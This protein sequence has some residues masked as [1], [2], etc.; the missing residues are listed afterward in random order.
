MSAA[1]EKVTN[2]LQNIL[3][4]KIIDNNEEFKGWNV[5][6]CTASLI[7]SF[8][9][10]LSSIFEVS[11]ILEDLNVGRQSQQSLYLI[12]KLMKQ[13]EFFRENAK[14]DEL[15]F[16]EFQFYE[17]I[18][19]FYSE[20]LKRTKLK[21]KANWTPRFY[22][23]S[24]G[25]D[26]DIGNGI[27]PE[28]VFVFR[29]LTADNYR[30]GPREKLD[31]QHI[32]L[33]IEAIAKFH[34]V[35][36]ALKIQHK[37]K[38]TEFVKALKPF[39]FTEQ[40]KT[41]FDALYDI[42]LTRLHQHV[43]S[44]QQPE[45][46]KA[47]IE[48][49]YRNYI[50]K[51]SKLLQEFI[52]DDSQFNIII[53]G[54]YN[55]NNVM[56]K[57]EASEGFE[58]P[59]KVKMF[60]FQWIRYASP[61]LDISFCLYMNLDPELFETLWDN[62]LKFYHDTMF[63]T[64]TKILNC[65]DNDERIITLDY[66]SFQKHF[67]NYAFYGCL[68]SSW[69]I[70]IML[71]DFETCKNIEKELNKDLFS[72]E[73]KE[74][75][76]PAGGKDAVERLILQRNKNLK[77]K[78]IVQC[79][80]EACSTLDG[81]M[82]AIYS[83]TLELRDN[84]GYD[85]VLQ[86]IVKIMKGDKNFRDS[87]N[88]SIQC[89]NEVYIYNK[90]IPYFKKFLSECKSS[91]S[92]DWI[93]KVYFSDYQIFPE[94]SE[95]KE[96]ILALENLKPLGYRL[97]PRIDLDEKH[98]RL[99]ITH[100]ASY[101]AVSYAMRIKKDPMLDELAKG[102]IPFPYIQE[103]GTEMESY[104]VLFTIGL[105]RFFKVIKENPKLENEKG[106]LEAVKKFKD[107]YG[108]RPIYLLKKLMET[109][110]VFSILLHGD[111]N[112][113]NVLFLYD[114]AEGHENPKGLKMIDFQE[115]RYASPAIDL[116]F[117]MYMNMHFTL[118]PTLW[119]PVLELYH[120]T[121]I[122]SISEIL[123][124]DK[125]D[126]RL[127]P[128]SFNNFINHFKK[129]AFYGVIIGIHFIPWMACPEDEC[130]LMSEYWEADTNSPELR[131]L[132]QQKALI[133]M[134]KNMQ[135]KLNFVENE[136]PKLMMSQFVVEGKTIVRCCAK[137]KPQLDGFMSTIFTAD[138]LVRDSSG[139]ETLHKII[140]KIMKGEED[141][142]QKSKAFLQSSNE[143]FVY[144]TIIP[145]FSI[146]DASG[147]LSSD[148]W[149]SKVYFAECGN[150][151]SLSD[152]KETVVVLGDLNALGYRMSTSKLVLDA[153]HLELMA[154]KIA[155]YH[156]VSFAMKITKDPMFEKL[157]DGLTAFHIKSETQGDLDV[158]K[159]LCPIAFERA[160]QY[161]DK[162]EKYQKYQK[163]IIDLNNFKF[164]MNENFMSIMENFLRSDHQFAVILH[165]DYYRNNVMFKYE[166]ENGK[167][168]PTDLKMFDFQQV[169]YASVAIDLSFFMYMAVHASM[170]PLIWDKLLKV[171]HET[172]IE[173]MMRILMCNKDDERL[174]PYN[175]DDF[176]RN[177]EEFAFY[178]VVISVLLIPW[179][180]SPESESQLISE[181]FESDMHNPQFKE[182][183]L[184]CG[185]TDQK[186][187]I[188]MTKNM[189][190][191]LNF[192]ENELPKLMMSQFVVEG[193]T[194]VRCC[195]KPKPQLDGFMST[196]FT[197]DMLVKDASG[198]ETLHKI[199]VKIMKGEEDF[200]QK[201]KAF[202]QS[203]NEVFVYKTIIPYFSK[204]A[205]SGNL[206]SDDWISKVYFVECGNFE[207]LSDHKETIVV[208]E[209]LNA[210]GY[211]MSTS[212]LVLDAIHLELMARKIA[213]Y[214]AVS[215]AMKITKDLMFEKLIDG[216][217]PFHM[218]SETQGDL[219]VYKYLCPIAFERAFQYIDKSENYQ[220][221]QKFMKDLKNF[222][223]RMNENFM[224]IM[225]NFLRSDHQFAVI[226]HGDY[227]R[228]NVMFKYE[229][230]NG[231]EIPT[232]LKMFDFQEVRYA[233]VAIDLSIFMYMAVHASMKPLIWDELL[234]VYHETIIETLARILM[235]NKDDERFQP[236]NFDDFI[237]NF[238]E[239]AFYA[240][241]I[242]VLSIPWMASPESESQLIS[243][244]FE[245]DMHNP[246]FKELLLTC[247]GTDV[248]ERIID[249]IK[250]ANFELLAINSH[251]EYQLIRI[252]LYKFKSIIPNHS[253]IGETP[254]RKEQ[255]QSEIKMKK[256]FLIFIISVACSKAETFNIFKQ[257]KL[258]T[259]VTSRVERRN[260]TV[261]LDHFDRQNNAEW[262]LPYYIIDEFYQPNGPI[263]LR[264]AGAFDII[265]RLNEGLM[266]DLA[267]EFNA[268]IVGISL[269]FYGETRPTENLELENLRFLNSE[270][271]IG[272]IAH[273]VTWIKES[274]PS[275]ADSK[276]IAYGQLDGGSNAV[277]ARSK[278]PHLID[279][280][281]ASS[282][283]LHAVFDF[284]QMH[285]AI[286]NTLV[287]VGG[288]RC[289]QQ[290]ERAYEQ[291][292][293]LLQNQ[294]YE[295]IENSLNLCHNITNTTL[296]LGA[297]MN[298]LAVT[299]ASRFTEG[300]PT[301]TEEFCELMTSDLNDDDAFTRYAR[302]TR[303]VFSDN[304]IF[305][306]Y[307]ELRGLF[308]ANEWTM[309]GAQ[310]GFRQTLYQMCAEFG[311][312]S[313]SS[314]QYQPFGNRFPAEIFTD[315]CTEVFG[316]TFDEDFIRRQIELTNIMLG[317]AQPNVSNAY[318]TNGEMDPE[319]FLGVLRDINPT[320]RATVIP[321][322]GAHADTGSID[323][324]N[325][326]FFL[327]QSKLRVKNYITG[328]LVP[329][330]LKQKIINIKGA[331]ELEFVYIDSVEAKELNEAFSLAKPYAVDVT[332]SRYSERDVKHNFHLVVKITPICPPETYELMG[333]DVLF[334]NEET[335]FRDIIPA[336]GHLEDFPKYYYS[337]REKNRAVMVLGNF[338]YD[339]WKMSVNRV[340]LD[341]NHILVAVREL[342][343]FHGECYALKESNRGLFHIITK[344]FR[345]SRFHRDPDMIW[346]TTL[347]VSPRR[348][349]HAIR[350]NPEL[351]RIIPEEF[352]KKIEEHADNCWE[353][354][355][356]SVQPREPL[357]IICHGDYLRNNI[358][359][360]Y[361][362][363]AP[364]A[365]IKAMMFD[366]QTL[367]YA[368]PMMDLATF[369]AN[370]TGT[371]VRSTHFSFI[372]KTYH[373]EV[374]KTLMNTMKKS[375]Q[376]ISEVYSYDNFLREYARLSLYGYFIA[377][378]FLQML[379]E[380]EEIDFANWD[381]SLGIDFIIDKAMRHG[382]EVVNYELAGLIYDMF[383]LHQKLNIDLE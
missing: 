16:N 101:H 133:K 108:H 379:H 241:V 300:P 333:F 72:K 187:L 132:A 215:F 248:S 346:G 22:F 190:R 159:Y 302:Y 343:K 246:Q 220:K 189:Q 224:S 353:Y 351:K 290:I 257:P 208:L 158:Y 243:E 128:Y 197:A 186:A 345:E 155:T 120:E 270:Q 373:E 202:L 204:F 244:Y 370:S 100:I 124:C 3:P 227:Y 5:V 381:N 191:K 23:G 230:K 160:F 200:R 369:L 229:V 75:C 29:N 259:S 213:T 172:I 358:A 87:T 252:S 354:M 45:D 99:M 111:Y 175:F 312:F 47:A 261:P 286:A 303:S 245:S 113:N 307:I 201:S 11:L 126:E 14:L 154:R 308:S 319:R 65:S 86:M 48:T 375:R 383:K 359:F 15:T 114:E 2:F 293:Q 130:Q 49:I 239:F 279:G 121:L 278:Y 64:L 118:F 376:E 153:I 53:H 250:H 289:Y 315:A 242:S 348:G 336:L 95:G 39:P 52:N 185:G 304:C 276:V 41:F 149:I 247:G 102:L 125:S 334:E 46:F 62:L 209:D 237:R 291:I 44:S 109:D 318:L 171:Y 269:R 42:A 67:T 179:M 305:I 331:D 19:P 36:Y 92:S 316:P 150:F 63:S 123:K 236:Y 56:F 362:E 374:I 97:G 272:D 326:S 330:L 169:R 188:K 9:G 167:E 192:V 78:K 284:T 332:L 321:R 337:L 339:G 380:P 371:D 218:K 222:K 216:L 105:Q 180:A 350:E 90:V 324:E 13:M 17:N 254:K 281:W 138:M 264:V 31:E 193:K 60:D 148:D 238:E 85:N 141:F 342:G 6:S 24:Y 223:F 344:A 196:I 232:D 164:R 104:K 228:N 211:R 70:P 94:L 181:Y 144:K 251:E 255:I 73:S 76:L 352:L 322:V 74:A 177:F 93:P 140:V 77:E 84:S 184:T 131:D 357:A 143:V 59:Q 112:R 50:D 134:T 182:L 176:I 198:N 20:L 145:Y 240:V 366:F 174:Q 299:Y 274:D 338:G 212:K 199:I 296:G 79:L 183:L 168:I 82:S 283:R 147:N 173:T 233:S 327:T 18:L 347:K 265:S 106:F 313:T 137:P 256:L 355:K 162:N 365:P 68:I 335:A 329:E 69:F 71:A 275:L 25:P 57:Y 298:G 116:V 280:V 89:S 267:K 12:V 34:A 91:L 152:H 195:A 340:N 136:L 317:G 377:A 341:L 231:K 163:F 210:L 207:S 166:V 217:T 378:S 165:G 30:M 61:V 117:F 28:G 157:I 26:R 258:P 142:R 320:A 7:K 294:E 367:R 55:R 54:D 292:E 178:G 253:I 221:D 43:S 156:A 249:N 8:D 309:A 98:L 301:E 287:Q 103:D 10:F 33:M 277:W 110:D 323:L 146:F 219:D 297:L 360:K 349:T 263:F 32:K 1:S 260:V 58:N 203:S 38:Q 88:S 285:E 40:K 80:A 122:S 37:E 382:G 129:F 364:H 96:T 235:C 194:I 234:K 214:H 226:L 356:E 205:A 262:E 311:R 225:E 314:S 170:K 268:L 310:I 119:D 27:N 51:P 151:E 161:V 328:K 273:L 271:A 295:L 282:A 83:V 4:S 306:D 35:S 368:S 363:N 135:R 21:L 266:Y 139:N 288:L 107:Q 66:E 127:S 81:F 361:D 325:D 206:S 372:F 115:T